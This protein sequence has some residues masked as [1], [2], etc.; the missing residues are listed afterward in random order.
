MKPSALFLETLALAEAGIPEKQYEVAMMYYHGEEVDE[1]IESCLEWMHR[2]Y[3]QG[4]EWAKDFLEEFY[5]DDDPN[6][7]A[8]S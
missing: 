8:H 7:Q 1:D 2:S 3:D 4:Y 5:F 6:T